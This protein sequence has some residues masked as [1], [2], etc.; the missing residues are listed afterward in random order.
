MLSII[1]RYIL[2]EVVKV[3]IAVFGTVLLIVFGMLFLQT[4]EQVNAGAL[5]PDLVL[6][7][8]GLK[9]ARDVAAL[10]PPVFFIA[11]L[12]ALGRMARDSELIALGACGL[13][14]AQTYRSLFLAAIPI[15]M[16]TSWLS[17][18]LSPL[19]AGEIQQ[20][21]A[22]Q[23]EQVQQIATI[24]AG[25]FY[26][27]ADGQITV[28]VEEIQDNSSLRNIFIH[29]R[30]D[31]EMRLIL[32]DRGML[33]N[34]KPSGEQ[35]VTLLEGRRYDGMPGEPD[36]ALGEFEKY[37]LRVEPRELEA[38]R[39]SKRAT[40]R[41]GELVG[42]DD[43]KDKAELQQRIS[44]PLAV[45]TLTILSVPLTTKSPRQ[46]GA[47]RL[48]LAFLTYFSFFNLQRVATGWYEMG[49]TPPWLGSLWYQVLI[50]VL[51]LGVLVPD[52]AWLKRVRRSGG[53][54]RTDRG[55]TGAAASV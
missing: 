15:A 28:Y 54:G 19:A 45:L 37:N 43:I 2:R 8:M 51:V 52:G 7:F 27:Q 46:S 40:Y 21:R 55:D 18:H 11:V 38:M 25:R 1:D 36:Y 12:A 33:R 23:K 32:S 10:L 29:D 6:R 20:I 26:Q 49:A 47:W 35:F 13:G 16:L 4:L 17:F 24:K 3:F 39:T 50:L 53:R 42:S 34:D 5:N 44:G 31:G 14:P 30:R 41:T 9:V 48:F 22:R